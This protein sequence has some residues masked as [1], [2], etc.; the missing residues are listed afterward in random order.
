MPLILNLPSFDLLLIIDS[1]YVTDFATYIVNV[2]SGTYLSRS[3][4]ISSITVIS[5]HRDNLEYVVDKVRP[6]YKPISNL[7]ERYSTVRA[8]ELQA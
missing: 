5:T 8:G 3:A 4:N 7:H 6:G 1:C 2:S